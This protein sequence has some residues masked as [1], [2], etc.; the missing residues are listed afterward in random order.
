MLD[1][2][3]VEFLGEIGEDD[4]PRSW[5]A[6]RLLFPIDWPEPFGLVMIEAMA[7]GTRSSRGRAAR[8]E[9]VVD[10]PHRLPGR[11]AGRVAGRGERVERSI[12]P[13]PA[14]TWRPNSRLPMA[15]DYERVYRR[16]GAAAATQ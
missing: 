15:E 5:A 11:H 2:P 16:L 14:A 9:V 3:L 12:A 13:V 10:G 4:S 7:C 8:A 1:D 6:P